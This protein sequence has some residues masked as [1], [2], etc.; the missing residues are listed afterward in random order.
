M[1]LSFPLSK[2][3]FFLNTTVKQA[4][5]G[6]H[7]S[8]KAIQK[9]YWALWKRTAWVLQ[10]VKEH[11]WTLIALFPSFNP[12]TPSA[13]QFD[14]LSRQ[15]QSRNT[16]LSK[17]N[18]TAKSEYS[19]VS[20]HYISVDVAYK[21]SHLQLWFSLFFNAMRLTSCGG[22]MISYSSLVALWSNSFL[23][24]AKVPWLF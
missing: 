7:K 8:M 16:Q 21:S 11:H 19:S 22:C 17:N 12:F 1:C 3:T 5:G 15:N 6:H 13:V 2:S 9:L 20:P 4:A 14:D 23:V 10:T 24:A 18:Q